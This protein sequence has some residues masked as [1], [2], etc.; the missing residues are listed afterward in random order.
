MS[1]LINGH[2]LFWCVRCLLLRSN[3]FEN[4]RGLTFIISNFFVESL[5]FYVLS[6]SLSYFDAIDNLVGLLNV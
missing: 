2:F 6:I 5:E 3:I 1:G 4:L